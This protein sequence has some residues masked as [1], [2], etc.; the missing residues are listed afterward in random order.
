MLKHSFLQALEN[1]FRCEN[2]KELNL[3]GQKIESL[4]DLILHKNSQVICLI[5]QWKQMEMTFVTNHDTLC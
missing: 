3:S 5:S 1:M 2:V 4:Y